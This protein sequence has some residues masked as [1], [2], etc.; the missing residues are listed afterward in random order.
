[1]RRTWVYVALLA[2]GTIAWIPAYA[3]AVER[4]TVSTN[5]RANGSGLLIANSQTNPEDETW[6][7]RACSANLSSCIAFGQGREIST[8]GARPST[9]FRATSSYGATAVSSL[10]RGSLRPLGPPAVSGLLQANKRITPGPGRWRGGWSDDY[11]I[12]QLAACKSPKG[13]HCT[14]LTDL[15]YPDS[16]PHGAAVL[17]PQFTGSYLRVADRRIGAGTGFLAFAVPTPYGRRIWG[18][19]RIT[20][21]AIVG[22]IAVATGPRTIKCGPPPLTEVP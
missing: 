8:S 11:D 17:D 13:L 21:V 4:A 12:F 22:R 3:D 20:S 14:T 19:D 16:C 18:A 6:A 5:L 2:A 9:R 10:W 15:N 1:M 7:W